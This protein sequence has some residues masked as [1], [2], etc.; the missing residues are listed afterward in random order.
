VRTVAELRAVLAPARREGLRIALVPTMGALHAGHISLVERARA[1][2]DVVVVSLFV[3]PAQFDDASDLER[4]PRQERRDA[5]LAAQ[6]G[7][8]VLF[9]PA[10]DEVYPAGFATSVEVAGL[11]E[12]LEGA[13]RGA[14]H[15]RGVATVVTKL[16]CMTLPDVAFFGEK[17]A[18]QVLVIRR[19]VADLDI[20]VK[21]ETGPTVR[22]AD[23]LALSSRNARLS[24]AERERA[25]ALPAALRA[26]QALAAAGER[27]A[28]ALLQS[29]REAMR[30]RGV[31]P[32]Y[33]ELAD[34]RT[35]ERRAQLEADAL[36]LVA[37]RI[38]TTRLIDNVTLSP[39]TD[40]AGAQAPWR[41]ELVACSE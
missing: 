8:D 12:K 22:E 28:S 15:F 32:E 33:V 41:K 17:D 36:L 27:S 29:A 13:A 4:Y 20:P 38:G 2:C 21:I 23:G 26:A 35:L 40:P 6:A 19:V 25:L 9:A 31:E 3:N 34:P 10:V 39:V 18:Q 30:T 16:L 1:T 7:A 11:T 5:E 37:A 14:S 24:A